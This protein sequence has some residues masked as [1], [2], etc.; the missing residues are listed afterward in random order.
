MDVIFCAS[1]RL[2]AVVAVYVFVFFEWVCVAHKRFC[3]SFITMTHIVSN[4]V[5]LRT[6]T[7]DQQSAAPDTF[8]SLTQL[9]KHHN[10][11]LKKVQR[12]SREGKD[13]Q[14]TATEEL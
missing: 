4:F 1:C 12:W 11:L 6:L 9:Y 2:G 8:A 14:A 3:E 5:D 10:V 13:V 7:K